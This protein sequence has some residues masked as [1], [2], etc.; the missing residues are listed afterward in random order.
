[1][2][3]L[4]ETDMLCLVIVTKEEDVCCNRVIALDDLAPCMH[5]EADS[6]IFLT[7]LHVVINSSKAV[8]KS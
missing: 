8:M 7:P 1:M 3:R 2:D 6:R 5:E 4:T